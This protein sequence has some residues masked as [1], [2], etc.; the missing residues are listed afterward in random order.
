MCL[1]T[2]RNP[3]KNQPAFLW[4]STGKIW[5]MHKAEGEG[6]IDVEKDRERFTNTKLHS[7][8]TLCLSARVCTIV[9]TIT[10]RTH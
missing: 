8:L 9:R 2:R 5:P 7:P 4:T 6:E 10:R 3:S 1:Q